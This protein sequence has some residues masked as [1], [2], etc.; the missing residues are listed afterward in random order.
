MVNVSI[1]M[2]VMMVVMMSAATLGVI[3]MIVLL[4]F[5]QP[6][7]KGGLAFRVGLNKL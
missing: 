7:F 5:F 6:G 2:I 3:G 4:L 1:S